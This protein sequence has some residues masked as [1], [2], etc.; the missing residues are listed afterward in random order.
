MG[1]IN[2]CT[3]NSYECLDGD[4]ASPHSMKI[5]MGLGGEGCHVMSWVTFKEEGDEFSSEAAGCSLAYNLLA[6]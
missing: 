5:R 6:V 1:K 3:D 2:L 4:K